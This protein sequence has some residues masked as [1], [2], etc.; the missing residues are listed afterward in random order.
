MH[1][2]VEPGTLDAVSKQVHA[3]EQRLQKVGKSSQKPSKPSS[4]AAEADPDYSQ[5]AGLAEVVERWDGVATA[6][7][8]L[9][10]RLRSLGVSSMGLGNLLLTGHPC[11]PGPA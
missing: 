2:Q 1:S 9:I 3:L 4:Q 11:F 8:S 6:L 10:Q 5:L 7:P